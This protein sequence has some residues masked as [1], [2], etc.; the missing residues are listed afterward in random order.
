MVP[1]EWVLAEASRA[2]SLEEATDALLRRTET[3]GGGGASHSP[4][5]RWN[6]GAWHNN[7]GVG[8][9]GVAAAEERQAEERERLAAACVYR[10]A[11][12]ACVAQLREHMRTDGFDVDATDE[13]GRTALM[14]AA[15][16]CQRVNRASSNRT[17]ST[18]LAGLKQA[19]N[20]A[21][22]PTDLPTTS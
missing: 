18:C 10:A 13:H 7:C 5:A 14:I 1:E 6:A 19:G 2:H 12:Y 11:Q 16:L 3:R 17:Q 22:L 4:G 8:A 20:A 9:A 15:L 21:L